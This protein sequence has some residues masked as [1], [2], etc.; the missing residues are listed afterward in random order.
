MAAP[1]R[2]GVPAS[3]FHSIRR[4]DQGLLTK[5]SFSDGNT[6]P[7]GCTA[8][9]ELHSLY[10]LYHADSQEAVRVR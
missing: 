10:Y 5:T 3:Y 9:M 4:I 6:V 2:C 1:K 7:R 8:E